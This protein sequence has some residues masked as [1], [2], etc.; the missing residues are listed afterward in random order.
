MKALMKSKAQ[1][2]IWLQETEI[3]TIGPNDVLIKVKSSAICGTDVHIY[4]WDE[5][6]QKTIPVPMTVGH[7]FSG[8]VVDIGSEVH[9]EHATFKVGDRVS[10]EGHVTCGYCRNCRAGK[11]H[12]C[13]NTVGIGVNRPGSF[14]EYVVAPALNVYKLP[15][16]I[17]D[18]LGAIFDPF[19]NAAHTA[20]EFDLVG[21]DILITG[22]GPIGAMAGCIAQFVGARNIVVTDVNPYR[23][24]LAKSLGATRVVNVAKESLKDVMIEIGM[25]E[26]FDVGLEMSGV[27]SAF[28]QMLNVMNHG[29]KIALLG[30]MPNGAGIEWDQVI[31][32]GLEIRGIYGRRMFETWYKMGAMLQ[33]GLNLEPIITHHFPIEEYQQGFD[34]MRSGQSGKVILEW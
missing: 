25:S 13:R 21:E 19:G 2:G 3:P 24:A 20:L 31:F 15:D 4:N 14:A 9:P 22:A 17:S 34:I 5:W 7:E 18:S 29:G 1:E 30:I 6:A 32:K 27:P 26:G 28:T 11:R 10:A 16:E 12:L 33:A 8:V 23:L